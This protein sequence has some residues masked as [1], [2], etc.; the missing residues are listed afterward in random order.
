[1][2]DSI[3]GRAGQ[4]RA[5]QERT[6]SLGQGRAAQDRTEQVRETRR[7]RCRQGHGQRQTKTDTIEAETDTDGHGCRCS[8][9]CMQAPA[10]CT[11]RS[12]E[13]LDVS[14]GRAS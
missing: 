2:Q 12:W 6:S 13:C 3:Q 7:D 14:M 11:L 1:M 5:A 9:A 8:R 4:D 10:A